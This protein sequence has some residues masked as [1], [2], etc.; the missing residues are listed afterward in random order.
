MHSILKDTYYKAVPS[1]IRSFLR[2]KR[3]DVVFHAAMTQFVKDPGAC[4]Q[5]GNTVLND[6]I[7]GWG[8]EAWSAKEE[9]LAAC[10][11]HALA[12]NGAILEC[13][14]GL[15]SILLAAIAKKQGLCHCV[16]EHKPEWA[17]KVQ[18]YLD[19]Y[20]LDSV[21]H[22]KPLKDYG[23]F[24]WYDV[25]IDTIPDRFALVACDGP[26]GKMK[27]GRYGLVPIMGKRLKS[28]CIILLDDAY[29]RQELE[30][31]E[32]WAIEL[33]STFTVL[34]VYKPYLM[35]TVV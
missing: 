19:N 28:G 17:E 23:D 26:P 8:N 12:S 16:L 24:C 14:S 31:A 25:P 35:M 15:S 7:Y 21:I 6:L 1:P 30:I 13:G 29:R 27:G 2:G 5:P 33:D 32:R 4:T 10:I 9:Y 3:R 18:A 34:G 22:T 11:N 20:N